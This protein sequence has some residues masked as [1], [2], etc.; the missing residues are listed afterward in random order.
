M[1][2]LILSD[3]FFPLSS[4]GAGIIAFQQ[5][6]EFNRRGHRIFVITTVQNR[7]QEG[8]TV[9]D[10]ITVYRI[11]SRYHERWRSWLSLYNPQTVPKIEKLISDIKPDII[12]VHNVHFHLSYYVLKIAKKICGK[13]ILTLHDA[14]SYSCGKVKTEARI[15]FWAELKQYRFRFNPFRNF[16]IKYY[17]GFVD[18]IISV[19]E[20][21]ARALKNNGIAVGAVIHNGIDLNTWS[22]NQEAENKFK[23]EFDLNGKKVILFGGRLSWD[24]GAGVI[25][26]A[27]SEVVKREPNAI[28]LVASKSGSISRQME[29]IAGHKGISQNMAFIGWLERD[30]MKTAYFCSDVVATPSIYLDPF[31]TVN[32]E[33]M[34]AKKPV[35]GTCFG[36]TPEAITDDFNGYIVD[37]NDTD[38]LT[39]RI[40]ELLNSPEKSKIFGNNGFRKAEQEFNLKKQVNKYVRCYISFF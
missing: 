7:E 22:R 2:I 1:K 5:A 17:L 13:V 38:K 20:S 6:G 8:E 31:P 34:A 10:G 35:V 30:D 15:S 12:H 40:L 37:P 32:L 25:L 3:D 19:S 27:M 9:T 28:L 23:D 21:L 33:A 39:E 29:E 26:E 16:V 11:Y 36:G 14:M 18:Q 4:G 24:K